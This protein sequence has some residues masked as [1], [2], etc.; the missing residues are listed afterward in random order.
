MQEDGVAPASNQQEL[1]L[2]HGDEDQRSK[3]PFVPGYLTAAIELKAR[4]GE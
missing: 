2:H 4:R 3:R 1:A